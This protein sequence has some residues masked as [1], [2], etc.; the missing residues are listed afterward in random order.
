MEVIKTRSGGGVV[1]NQKG[2]ILVISQ[3][4]TSWSL[5]KGHVEEGEDEITAAKREIYEESGI[6]DL[7][8]IKEFDEYQRYR[9]D[10]KGGDDFSEL[11]TIKI[12]LF[13]TK[14]N[15]LKPVDQDNPEAK[16]LEKEK[17]VDLLTHQK[18]K[19]F[20]L[21]VIDKL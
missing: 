19:E 9:I 12:F 15:I 3:H 21:S 10:K 16:W 6:S 2:K 20:F 7:E 8:L 4:G 13:K 14:Q 5:P 11:K 18:D 1:V 17:V